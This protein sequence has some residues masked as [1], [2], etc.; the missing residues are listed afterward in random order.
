MSMSQHE[1][2]CVGM[3]GVYAVAEVQSKLNYVVSV[4]HGNAKG[5]DILATDERGEKV[6]SLQVKS[7]GSESFWRVGNKPIPCSDRHIFVF[8]KFFEDSKQVP[9]EIYVV[10]SKD[11]EEMRLATGLAN[12]T[13]VRRTAVRK[14]NYLNNWNMFM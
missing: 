10:P 9:R 11:A 1:K 7:T 4:T 2:Y 14:G 6:F 12:K 5:T 8:V 13:D 3:R